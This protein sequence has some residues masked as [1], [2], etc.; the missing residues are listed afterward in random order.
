[1]VLGQVIGVE[2]GGVEPL[3]LD[4]ALAVDLIEAQPG[5]RLDVVEDSES[6]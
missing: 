4:Q 5:H 3:D 1:V 2:S 6:Q